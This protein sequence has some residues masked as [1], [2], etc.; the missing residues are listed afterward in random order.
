VNR[1][2]IIVSLL[3]LC[4]VSVEATANVKNLIRAIDKTGKPTA[5][6]EKLVVVHDRATI[7]QTPTGKPVPLEP[8]AIFYHIKSATGATAP[9]NG[10][11]RVGT[12]KGVPV[13]WIAEDH[14]R[15]WNTR[16]ILDPIEPQRNRAFAVNVVGGG[17]ATQNATP[18][19]KRRYAL[20]V[21]SPAED[22][23]DD[24]QFPVVVYAGNVQGDGQGGTLAAERNRL[25]NVKL[26]IV[27][28]VEATGGMLAKFGDDSRSLLDHVVEG[29][30]EV[31]SELEKDKELNQAVRFGLVEYND[32]SPIAPFISNV[33][34]DLTTTKDEFRAYLKSMKPKELN[35]DDAP[36]DGIAGLN[37][38]VTDVSWSENSVKH[39]VTLGTG[40]FHLC[41]KGTNPPESGARTP[42]HQLLYEYDIGGGPILKA[43]YN[44]T[45]YRLEQLI[46]RARPQGGANSRAR[47]SRMFHA[48]HF[49]VDINKKV[50]SS[51]DAETLKSWDVFC[52][53]IN[54]LSFDDLVDVISSDGGAVQLIILNYLLTRHEHQRNLALNQYRTVSL[55]NGEADGV[56]RMVPPDDASRQAAVR[57]LGDKIKQTFEVLRQVREEGKELPTEMSNELA[58]PLYTLVGAAAIKFKDSPVLEGTATLRN[59]GGREIAFKK[60]MVAEDELRRL[61]STLDAL[62]TK[63][64]SMTRKAER[65]DVGGILDTMKEII[66]ETSAGQELSA[67]TKLK[68]LISTLPLRTAALDTTPQDLALMTSNSFTEWLER[69][70]TARSRIDDLLSERQEWMTL[71]ELAE[72]EK[73]T[74][75]RLSE[76]P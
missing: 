23:G 12:S 54:G 61:R 35:L 8:W 27:F 64:Q 58:Q 46:S 56:Y 25:D 72:N 2:A 22:E 5:L 43:G 74:F 19:G 26:E 60:V 9:E 11:L 29:I 66:A 48:L 55:N 16:F 67:D 59:A 15:K 49:G 76:L 28:A 7:S 3:S 18:E 14:V 69:L 21:D 13:G 38:A 75:L 52:E 68:D 34:C 17:T 20:I 41:S 30:S 53:T 63:F 57:E 42:L 65:Q 37:T 50:R 32:S 70:V 44:S 73:F 6:Y 51:L 71:S 39:I 47:S 1:I 40:A 62:H 33:R 24:T 45:G 4:F 36:V 31:V 10:R